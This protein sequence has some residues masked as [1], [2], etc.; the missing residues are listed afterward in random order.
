MSSKRRYTEG[1]KKNSGPQ[2][3]E[4]ILYAMS[5]VEL[6]LDS[7]PVSFCSAIELEGGDDGGLEKGH[8]GVYGSHGHGRLARSGPDQ[9]ACEDQPLPSVAATARAARA[10]LC[11]LE[12]EGS[13]IK[14][15]PQQLS[16]LYGYSAVPNKYS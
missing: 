1:A 3:S 16:F 5:E 6:Q 11:Q 13:F 7:V 4:E 9:S 10:T 12:V 14:L 15:L 8:C 2:A